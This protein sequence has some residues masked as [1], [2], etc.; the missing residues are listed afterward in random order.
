MI[1][2]VILILLLVILLYKIVENRNIKEHFIDTLDNVDIMSDKIDNI[3]ENEKE[4]RLFCKIIRNSSNKDLNQKILKQKQKLF[5]YNL[6]K[7]NDKISEIKKKIINFRLNKNN[8]DFIDFNINKNS[9]LQ[10]NKKRKKIIDIAKEK[11][12]Q[13]PELN[14][15]MEHN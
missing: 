12:R 6:K 14:I 7:Q 9:K 3:I 1:K 15:N 4:T 2:V 11:I 10:E 8:K 13:K 5:N